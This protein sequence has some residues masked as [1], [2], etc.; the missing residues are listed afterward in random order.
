MISGR[1]IAG[2]MVYFMAN[3]IGLKINAL[4]YVKGSIITGL[5]GIVIQLIIIPLVI[6]LLNTQGVFE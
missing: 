3:I 2:L 5:P 4:L 1:V 6:K